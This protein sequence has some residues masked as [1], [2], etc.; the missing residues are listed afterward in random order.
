M[1]DK[2]L[3]GLRVLDLS[4]ILAGP[5]STQ[6]LGDLGAEVIKVENPGKGDDSRQWGPPWDGE[7]EDKLSAYYLSTNRGKQ[8]VA[9]DISKPQGQELIRQLA[10]KSDILVENFKTGGLNKYGL[11]YDA[12][13]TVNP[14]LI[15]CSITGFGQNGPRSSQPGYDF[16]IQGIS[17]MMSVTGDP[18]N[19]PQKSGVAYVDIL[20]GLHATIAILAAINQRH[21]TGRGQYI[22][23][24]LFD[25]AVSTMANQSLNYLIS[26]DVPVQLGNAHPNVVPY[27]A[28]A[29]RDGHLIVAVGNDSQFARFAALAG[30]A[31]WAEDEKFRTN[32]GRINHREELTPVIAR[33]MET[34][35]TAAWVSLLEDASIPHGPIYNIAQALADPQAVHRG[36]TIKAG[37]RPGIASPLRLSDSPVAPAS[38]PPL[39]GENTSTVLEAVLG[40]GPEQQAQLRASGAIG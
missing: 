31:D 32:A 30:R 40:I 26:G 18:S 17:G 39:L 1:T 24:A 20:T 2:A 27:Q 3:S 34:R 29:T 19:G 6:M 36:L 25:V 33:I 22:D 9:I 16:M 13:K 11:D 15:Y 35:T 12:L 7:G 5:W 37:K 23:V 10:A 38:A 4:R 14:R 8:S 28:F 21:A